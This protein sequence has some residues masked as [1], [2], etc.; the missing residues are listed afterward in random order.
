MTRATRKC[1]ERDRSQP[2]TATQNFLETKTVNYSGSYPSV[3]SGLGV[4][5]KHLI[6]CFVL[7]A[8]LGKLPFPGKVKEGGMAAN[9]FLT[10]DLTI[11]ASCHF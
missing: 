2:N 7:T 9:L 1:D 6:L 11:L 4:P 3:V 8:F 5:S 10:G